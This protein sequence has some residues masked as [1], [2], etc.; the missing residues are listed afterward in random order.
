M[1]RL[2]GLTARRSVVDWP[3]RLLLAA[4]Q[5]VSNFAGGVVVITLTLTVLPAG[6]QLLADGRA[7]TINLMVVPAYLLVVIPAGILWVT[8]GFRARPEDTRRERRLVLYGPLR[9]SVA[10]GVGWQLAA[11]VFGVVNARF[12][13]L[14]LGLSVAETVTIGGFSTSALCYLVAERILRPSATRVL[15]GSAPRLRL[16]N[17]VGVRFV[18]FWVL[19]TAV[20]VSG[21]LAAGLSALVF[22]ETR[23]QDLAVLI[24]AIGGAALTTGFLTTV[25]AAHAISD[26][27]RAVRKALHRV[28]Q[29]DLSSTVQVYDG[30]ELGQLQAGFNNMVSGLRERDRIRDLFGRQVGQDV[31]SVTAAATEVRLGGEVREVAVLFV[32]LVGSTSLAAEREPTD[33]VA[34]LNRFFAVVVEVVERN[35]GWIN[36]FEGDAALAIFGAPTELDDVA[37]HALRAGRELSERL[38][39]E[40][41]GLQAGIGVSAGRALAGYVGDVRRYEY[42]VIG[43]PVNEAAR[44]TELA[45]NAPGGLLAAGTS[46]LAAGRSEASRWQLGDAVVLRGRRDPTRLASVSGVALVPAPA[47]RVGPIGPGQAPSTST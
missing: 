29:G 34:L 4:V 32:D 7:R 46:V 45:K 21:L 36:K 30:S 43:D 2:T 16:A 3:A 42:T 28:E 11:V 9:M 12:G 40:V 38:A 13:S 31:A 10:Q 37:G 1:A 18:L 39:V 35:Q 23:T 25:G 26:P 14:E 44:L 5:L 47:T 8:L 19:G 24:L 17:R 22:H 15:A 6:A 41:P 27:V 33:V 20:P